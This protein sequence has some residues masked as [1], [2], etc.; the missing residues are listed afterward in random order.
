MKAIK[1]IPTVRL[2]GLFLMFSAYLYGQDPLIVAPTVYKKAILENE[3]VRVIELE[4][5]P[6]EVIP[7]HSHPNHVIYAITDGKI[8]I[9]DK[10]KAPVVVDIKAGDALYI[11]AV[12]HMAKNIG[13]TSAKMVVTEIKS[14]KKKMNAHPVTAIKKE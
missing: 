2:I 1:L 3:N 12:T 8:E 13:T 14:N 11:P 6:G 4:I 7:W 10:G 5:A 9:T